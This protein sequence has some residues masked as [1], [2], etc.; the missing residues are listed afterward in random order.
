MRVSADSRIPVQML[1]GTDDRVIPV[2]HSEGLAES[3]RVTRLDQA[4]HMVHMERAAT[5]NE[6]LVGFF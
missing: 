6:M 1:W 4:G 3:I 2:T 5:V